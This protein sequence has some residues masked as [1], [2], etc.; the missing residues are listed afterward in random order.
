MPQLREDPC[1]AVCYLCPA[2]KPE[3][4]LFATFLCAN[5]PSVKPFFEF[6]D[7]GFLFVICS[8]FC[9]VTK[10]FTYTLS[11]PVQLAGVDVWQRFKKNR[12]KEGGSSNIM[13]TGISPTYVVLLVLV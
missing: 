11:C 9:L 1:T 4:R 2:Q 8:Y 3:G 10:E 5:V 12:T 13:A 7:A 6:A